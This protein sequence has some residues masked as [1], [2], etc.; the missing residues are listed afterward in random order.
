MVSA[1]MFL[2]PA[3]A[4][5][6]SLR[7][8]NGTKISHLRGGAEAHYRR[9]PARLY[10]KSPFPQAYLRAI[11]RGTIHA[12][13]T[14]CNLELWTIRGKVSIHHPP[15]TIYHP[16][17]TI[18]PSTHRTAMIL[19]AFL[20]RSS[21]WLLILAVALLLGGCAMFSAKDNNDLSLLDLI[22]HMRKSG[23]QIDEI[24]PTIYSIVLAEDGCALFIEGAKVEIYRYDLTRPKLK[25]KVE[26]IAETG[27][28]TILGIDFPA[29]VNGSFVMLTYTQHPKLEE[30]IHVFENF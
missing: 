18:H 11:V 8:T 24:Q 7:G 26:R 25:Q 4:M 27:Q 21:P 19:P 9:T 10:G 28:I 29:K 13:S 30:I 5:A 23:L 16:L 14:N 17:S 20:R 3:A 1:M 2:L 22:D 12:L 15:S 6:A